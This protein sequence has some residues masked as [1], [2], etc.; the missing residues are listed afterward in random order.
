MAR[1]DR[2][3]EIQMD[4]G[5]RE[6][7]ASLWGPKDEI[8]EAAF[9]LRHGMAMETR[10]AATDLPPVITINGRLRLQFESEDV[11]RQFVDEIVVIEALIRVNRRA[12][13]AMPKSVGR[14]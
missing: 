5:P 10:Q 7:P 4:Q 1:G 2:L 13:I 14:L 8:V 11:W 3:H 9:T 6:D 12:G